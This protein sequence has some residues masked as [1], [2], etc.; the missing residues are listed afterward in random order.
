MMSRYNVEPC[1]FCGAVDNL[2]YQAQKTNPCITTWFRY[3]A[4]PFRRWLPGED[5]PEG[6][7][8]V[9]RE[10]SKTVIVEFDDELRTKWQFKPGTGLI[11]A[12]GPIPEPDASY[13]AAQTE[14]QQ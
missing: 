11:A 12:I 2:R 9:L 10:N 3:P 5:V 8:W 13:G 1:P 6:W 7:Y 4:Q 14:V